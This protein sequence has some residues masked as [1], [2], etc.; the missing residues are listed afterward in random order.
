VTGFEKKKIQNI[1][2]S[3][4]G[5][6]RHRARRPPKRGGNGK[7]K[8]TKSPRER[9]VYFRAKMELERSNRGHTALIYRSAARKG[10]LSIGLESQREAKDRERQK[11]K[12]QQPNP[13]PERKKKKK[14]QQQKK[15]K[16]N[17]KERSLSKKQQRG[18]SIS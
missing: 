2:L 7:E 9:T 16:K 3:E 15:K 6:G 10:D 1:Y 18:K 8:K 12:Q 11:K 5:K 14:K 13:H 17:T 4:L